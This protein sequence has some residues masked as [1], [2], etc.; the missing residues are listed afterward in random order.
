[1]GNYKFDLKH[2]DCDIGFNVFN[3]FDTENVISKD[4]YPPYDDLVFDYLRFFQF[5]LKIF[6]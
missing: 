6:I 2:F 4:L 5:E 1:M 3:V